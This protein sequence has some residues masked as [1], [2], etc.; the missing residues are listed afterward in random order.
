LS[1][2]TSSNPEWDA[3][4]ASATKVVADGWIV[5]MA[6]PFSQLRFPHRESHTWGLNIGR[7]IVRR[8][9]VSRLVFTPKKEAGL[10]S[11]FANLTGIE[12]IR[13]GHGLELLPYTAARIDSDSE[14]ADRMDSSA[15]AGLDFKYALT[16]NLTLTGTVNPD[17]G[18]VEVDP[19]SVNL[20]QF[21]LFYSERRPFFVEGSSMFEPSVV[22]NHSFL[23]NAS[24]PMLFYSRR[25]GRVPQA[26]GA[27]R[28]TDA[29]A[30]T[31][32]LGA[33]KLTGKTGN[34]WT[35]A[36]LDAVTDDE[37]GRFLLNGTSVRRSVEPRTNYFVSRAAKDFG[38]KTSAGF[39]FTAVNRSLDE[40]LEPLLRSSAYAASTDGYRIFGN[41]AYVL[42]W[43]ASATRV[44]G[45]AAS[46]LSTQRSSARYYQR[47][48]AKHVEVD[49]N[50]TSLDGYGGRVFFVKH[51]GRWQYNLQ[52]MAYSPGFETNDVGYMPRTDVLAT[53]AVVL[54]SNP[55][56]WKNTRRRN[57]WIGKFQHWNWDGDL[58]QNGVWFDGNTTF[59]N[60]WRAFGWG[61]VEFPV[62]DDRA[63]RGGPSIMRP[64]QQWIGGQFGSD[65]RRKLSFDAWSEILRDEAG[66]WA[67]VFAMTGRFRPATNVSLSLTPRYRTSRRMDEYVVTRTNDPTA[68]ATYNARY[69]FSQIDQRTF[70]LSA[71]LDWTFTSRFSLQL[72]LQPY[73]SAGN[74]TRFKELARPR[75]RDFHEYGVDGGSIAYDPSRSSYVVDPDGPGGANAFRFGDP[76]F[77]YRSIRANAVA[78][79]EFRPGSTLY[80]VWNENRE[81][82]EP[83]GEFRFRRDVGES[84]NAPAQD[85]FMVKMSYWFGR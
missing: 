32:I 8:N 78:R 11:R 12:G 62:H 85:V 33:V 47:P 27:L 45:S 66:G 13:S 3:V 59:N 56:P 52:T 44:E 80:V 14:A 57:A 34:G 21:E 73:V 48:D 24:D 71:R 83:F 35:I 25:I 82:E 22:A 46:I 38:A 60:Y 28:A 75:S 20:T 40:H 41:N 15:S 5:E 61:G 55:D 54:Y 39:R 36:M 19:A 2:D 65:T 68:K 42:Q 50:R 69:L 18:Q 1:N 37:Q 67:D 23:F 29:P 9:E 76:N 26:T 6:I 7:L 81:E 70:E 17:F 31:T 64:R 10:V 53:H 43:A 63:T 74:Y 4:W 58:I 72:Y 51:S 49:P 84:F 30:Q 16:S 79:W 77:N